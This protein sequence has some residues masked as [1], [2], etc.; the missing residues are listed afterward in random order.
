MRGRMFLV[1]GLLIAHATA[2]PAAQAISSDRVLTLDAAVRMALE[3]NRNVKIAAAE[4]EKAAEQIEA[5]KSR[6]LPSF[7]VGFTPL[8]ATDLELRFGPLGTLPLPHTFAFATA[9]AALPLSQQY[10]IGLG[11]KAST[12]TRDLAAERLR[13]AR[14]TIANEVR[15]AYYGCL[16]AES[17]LKPAR[18]AVELFRE[19]ERVVGNLVAERAALEGDRLDAEVRRA[20]QEHDVLV[21][22]DALATG[23][24]RL[25]ATLARDIDAPFDLEQV[26]A[27]VPAQGELAAA[28]ARAVDS[29][30]DVRQ[31]RLAADLARTDLRLKK[32]EQLPHVG[33]FFTYVGS[34][35]MPLIPGNIG[36][37]VLQ[38]SWA[39]FTWGRN[40][41]ELAAKQLAIEQ[42]D[43]AVRELEATIGVDLNFRF[44]VLREARSL[45]T[46]TELGERAAR[47]HLRVMLDR[48]AEGAVLTRDLLQ[49][50]VAL[51]DADHKYQA[52]LLA[53]WDARADFERAAAEEP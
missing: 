20:Q 36:A 15:R 39:P 47:E 48:H 3:N 17:G 18:E 28:R 16:R 27:G 49:A 52:A 24:E 6:R 22:E 10:D 4:V 23:R 2:R 37:A 38:A 30:P 53:Y 8:A 7:N 5:A 44:R 42:A 46:V 14:Q 41:R 31:A 29:R 26:P 25:N 50:Q 21:L 34:I 40:S 51:A 9:T 12:V 43:T 32:A 45:V 19:L 33:A 13:D 11:V 1:A 35:N